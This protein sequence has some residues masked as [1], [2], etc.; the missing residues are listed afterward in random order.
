MQK[1]LTKFFFFFPYK[2]L[3]YVNK[4]DFL[5]GPVTEELRIP[6]KDREGKG[7]PYCDNYNKTHYSGNAT[8]QWYK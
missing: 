5:A 3:N 4:T 8:G 7:L 6:F 1:D 2:V